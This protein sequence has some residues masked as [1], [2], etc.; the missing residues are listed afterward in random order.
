MRRFAS[1]LLLLPAFLAACE[2][3]PDSEEAAAAAPEPAATPDLVPASALLSASEA[4]PR[5]GA[6]AAPA[7][8]PAAPADTTAAPA[9]DG[10]PLRAT[11]PPDM[12][13]LPRPDENGVTTIIW[14]DLMPEGEWERQQALYADMEIDHFGGRMPQIGDF[15][16]EE[17]LIGRVIRMP[18]FIL[19]LDMQNGGEVGEFLLVPYVGACV[20][21]PPPPPNQIVY[22]TSEDPV[23]VRELWYPVWVTGLLSSD[24]HLNGLG[25][26]AYTL[27]LRAYEPYEW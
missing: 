13:G 22:V 25:D 10:A 9:D 6:T 17:G 16:V 8:E 18:G 26:A 4:E 14:D 3:R 21:E 20:H 2:A 24:R 7:P 23:S 27:E 15:K 12:S 5:P 11:P 19:P 1:A